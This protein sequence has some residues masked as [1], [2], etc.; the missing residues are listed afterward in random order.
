IRTAGAPACAA[1]A[2]VPEAIASP[3]RSPIRRSRRA[4]AY[5]KTAGSGGVMPSMGKP[6]ARLGGSQ[7]VGQH[8]LAADHPLAERHQRHVGRRA[9]DIDARAEAD[10]ADALAGSEGL[11]L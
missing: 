11:P 7:P 9:V 4:A 6:R 5:T 10:N 3:R 8:R 2:P 1:A